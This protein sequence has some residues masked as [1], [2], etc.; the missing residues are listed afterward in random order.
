MLVLRFTVIFLIALAASAAAQSGRN[1]P[2]PTP[3]P[4]STPRVVPASTPPRDRIVTAT[5]TPT[6]TPSDNEEVIRVDSTLIPIPV[7]V[8]DGEGRAIRNL[9]LSDFEVKINGERVEL[10]ELT[11]AETPVRVALLFDNSGS[12]LKAREFEVQASVRFFERVIRPD[13]DL[14]ALFSISTI[15]RLEQPFTAEPRVLIEAIRRL[16]PPE[17]ATALLDTI[18]MAARYLGEIS[19]RRVIV[20]VSDG[21]D[22]KTDTTFE[23]ALRLAQSLDCQIFVVHTT[24]FENYIRTGS[25]RGNA[26]V[27]AL[28]AERRMQSFAA[29]TGGAV[30]TPIDERELDDAFRR[31]SVELA[32]QY[33]L[34]YYPEELR[35]APGEYRSIEVSVK[36][37]PD[38]TVRARKGYYVPKQR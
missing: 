28:A 20:I 30:Y 3:T 21:D 6:P 12:V 7:S 15:G 11:R 32:E 22:T 5:P 4:R 9:Q 17:G 18:E 31:I 36:A 38:V 24:E 35:A 2:E 1:K 34:S 16:P 14:A 23:Q 29:Q 26:N 13:R 19:G 33:V 27:R 37:R 10:A 25:R 8:V